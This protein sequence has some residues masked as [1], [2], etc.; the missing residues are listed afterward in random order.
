MKGRRLEPKSRRGDRGRQHE[1]RHE[2]N[3]S[4]YSAAEGYRHRKM[5]FAMLRAVFAT[6]RWES[7][8][9][10]NLLMYRSST[11]YVVFVSITPHGSHLYLFIELALKTRSSSI[12]EYQDFEGSKVF[13]IQYGVALF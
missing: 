11:C 9:G 4:C 7:P 1:L 8:M 2:K 10:Q 3:A 5:V 6:D 12:T 13:G